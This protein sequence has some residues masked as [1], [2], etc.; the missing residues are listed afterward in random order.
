MLRDDCHRRSS[1]THARQ[2]P[3]HRSTRKRGSRIGRGAGDHR[4][5]GQGRHGHRRMFDLRP[6]PCRLAVRLDGNRG[7]E[8]GAAGNI[9][10]VAGEGIVGLVATR[11]E[12][13]NL[14][15]AA[16]HPSYRYFPE[17]G[18]QEFSGPGGAAR[19]FPPVDGRARR[20]ANETRRLFAEDEVAFLVTIGAQLAA[21]LSYA[22]LGSN[23]QS[24][25]P[26]P[27]GA[28]RADSGLAGS[29]GDND[30][31]HCPALTAGRPRFGHQ[32][33]ARRCGAGR[34][35][36][37]AGRARNAGRAAGQC[38]PDGGTPV[39]RNLRIVRRL[40]PDP[41]TG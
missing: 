34:S 11:Q 18:E 7:P 20:A 13:I 23:V 37:Q 28:H 24:N 14:A 26:D 6:R 3:G 29:P 16:E 22:A 21:K 8:P 27:A 40:R 25:E 38:R 12:P 36:F 17:S 4:A 2:A 33:R 32:P 39:R 35:K 5:S 31:R 19:A 15:N 9:R 41:R 10:V 30:R 1:L